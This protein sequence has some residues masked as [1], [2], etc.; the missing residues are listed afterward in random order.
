MNCG[1]NNLIMQ[2]AIISYNHKATNIG[3]LIFHLGFAFLFINAIPFVWN[4]YGMYVVYLS[5]LMLFSGAISVNYYTKK[6]NQIGSIL[7]EENKTKFSINTSEIEII[8]AD[9]CVKFSKTGYEGKTNYI[10]FL[11]IGSFTTNPGINTI[12]FYN[13][14]R[15][16]SYEIILKSESEYKSLLNKLSNNY[17]N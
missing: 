6:V 8:N 10:P 15:K 7:F 11:T 2:V 3:M 13:D 12:C 5:L 17:K 4:N 1:R 9:Y 14:L 16:F